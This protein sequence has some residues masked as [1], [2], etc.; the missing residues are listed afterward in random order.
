MISRLKKW[1][2]RITHIKCSY[3][4]EPCKTYYEAYLFPIKEYKGDIICY[5]CINKLPDQHKIKRF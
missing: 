2:F 5:D 3:C 1:F 4:K